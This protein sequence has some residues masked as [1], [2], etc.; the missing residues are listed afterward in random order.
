MV[1]LQF[2]K[3]SP[4]ELASR[5]SGPYIGKK[6]WLILCRGATFF[7][8]FKAGETCFEHACMEHAGWKRSTTCTSAVT[9]RCPNFSK[10]AM[11]MITKIVARFLHVGFGFLTDAISA[12][13]SR[14]GW[15]VRARCPRLCLPGRFAWHLAGGSPT[16]SGTKAALEHRM[17]IDGPPHAP[18]ALLICS[19]HVHALLAP[20][21]IHHH[22]FFPTARRL[23]ALLA[24][25]SA[26]ALGSSRREPPSPPPDQISML[27]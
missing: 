24:I 7:S 12:V 18:A 10:R 22:H 9:T 1:F 17:T 6:I 19:V 26:L 2:C 23:L 4:W 3:L 25:C 15:C 13:S 5:G 16:V 11:M 8:F 20:D 21:S 27:E 14:I